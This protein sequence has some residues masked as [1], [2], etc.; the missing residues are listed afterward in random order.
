MKT[1]LA[2]LL[3]VSPLLA[4]PYTKHN[5]EVRVFVLYDYVP[6]DYSNGCGDCPFKLS[7]DH[8]EIFKVIRK[9]WENKTGAHLACT[10]G[11][12]HRPVSRHFVVLILDDV[13]KFSTKENGGGPLA[14]G[15]FLYSMPDDLGIVKKIKGKWVLTKKETSYGD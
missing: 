15:V 8:L 2:L 10:A 4:T 9:Y 1:I 11:K 12:E 13:A 6:T 14:S 7:G 5:E 3:L